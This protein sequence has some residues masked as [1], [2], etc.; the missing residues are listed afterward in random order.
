MS[1]SSPCWLWRAYP[2]N[3]CPSI[4][5]CCHLQ[6]TVDGNRLRCHHSP[7]VHNTHLLPFKTE[8]WLCYHLW[9]TFDLWTPESTSIPIC[10]ISYL[11]RSSVFLNLLLI[12]IHVICHLSSCCCLFPRQTLS[13]FSLVFL[14]LCQITWFYIKL[15]LIN[16]LPHAST[17]STALNICMVSKYLCYFF[18]IKPP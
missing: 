12:C 18:L 2:S 14:S 11:K 4:R 16:T 15:L 7:Q 1:S 6:H 5:S 8:I 10:L 3:P 17:A 13:H 9:G